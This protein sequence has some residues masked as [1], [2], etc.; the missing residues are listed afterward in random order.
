M[1]ISASVQDSPTQI[2]LQWPQDSLMIPIA[3]TV[4]RKAPG[5]TDWGS[6]APLPG[7][8]TRFVDTNVVA[9]T[10][11]EYQVV[12]TTAKH[13]GYGYILS[14]IRVP[15][16]EERGKVVL[17]VDNTHAAELS[18]ELSRLQQDLIG[19]GWTVLR[20]DV[21][22]LD[23]PAQ[24]KSLIK[25]DYEADPTKVKAVFLFGH[26]PV[27]RSGNYNVDGHRTRSMPADVFYGDMD[28]NWTDGNGDGVLDAS[29]LPSDVELEV[30][31]VD[32]SGLPGKLTTNGPPTFPGERELLR[33]YLNKNHAFRQAAMTAP[34]RALI[35]DRFGNYGDEAFAASGYRAFAAF[36]GATNIA[37]ANA[38]DGAPV[39]ER[40]ISLLGQNAYL[41]AFGSGGGNYASIRA[42]GTHPPY[43][44]VV[45]TDLVSVDAKA[46]FVM[47]FGSLLCEWDAEDDIMRA[48]LA[49]PNYGLACSWSGRPHLFYHRMGLGETIGAGLRL[50]QNNNGLYRN[51]VNL[52][53][54]GVHIALMGDPTLRLHPVAPPQALTATSGP[55]GV[56][57]DWTQSADPVEG[58]HTYRAATAAGPFARLTTA[59]SNE[60]RFHDPAPLAGDNTYM[61]R[62]VKLE[63]SASGTY[64]NASQGTFTTV[65]VAPAPLKITGWARDAAGKFELHWTSAPG[66]RYRVL[67][68]ASLTDARWTN[69][70]DVIIANGPTTSWSDTTAD[71]TRERFYA[72]T[73]AD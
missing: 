27:V 22:R 63:E 44:S 43:D 48:V 8:T 6:G 24:L 54:R 41:W 18:A 21:S 46:V 72:V 29:T 73:T 32:L 23:K 55:D 40:W 5:A 58:Y 19:D 68:K 28:G 2:T 13:T 71:A 53:L 60:N 12:K 1:Q 35:G 66:R 56:R 15:P 31:R 65:N 69:G 14:G 64:Y 7:E 36:F 45:T 42:L 61:V 38:D 67:T 59:L 70:S 49:T 26:I 50:S 3:Y 11:Y 9:G 30:G 57:L 17:L 4:H 33:Q 62:A 37:K 10:A 34:R 39:G 51:Q 52:H 47:M 20:H 25:S 16:T